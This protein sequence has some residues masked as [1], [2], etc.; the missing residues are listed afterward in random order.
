MD[1][2]IGIPQGILQGIDPVLVKEEALPL[3]RAPPGEK[4]GKDPRPP[5]AHNGGCRPGGRFI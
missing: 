1:R 3:L 5:Q 2:P 4:G